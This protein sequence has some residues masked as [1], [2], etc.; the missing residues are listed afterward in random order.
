[1]T[2]L[3]PATPYHRP[4]QDGAYTVATVLLLILGGFVVPV[5]GWF[6]G[7]VMLWAGT[8]WSAGEKW[9]GT[10]VWPVVVGLPTAAAALAGL[11]SD[12]NAGWT[13]GAGGVAG[14][15]T[16]L[17]VLPWVFVRLLRTARRAP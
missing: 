12:G 5:V 15:V 7:V 11:L 4:D 13:F 10:L 8:A 16:L 6:A 9:L 3:A 17:A 1:M 14:A 2:T